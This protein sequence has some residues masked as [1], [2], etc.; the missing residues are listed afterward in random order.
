M[1]EFIVKMTNTSLKCGCDNC[2]LNSEL[3]E[4]ENYLKDNKAPEQ[5]NEFVEKLYGLYIHEQLDHDVLKAIVDNNWSSAEQIMNQSGWVR[6][7]K[8][9]SD[10]YKITITRE[11][12]E[13]DWVFVGKSELY[14]D[15]TDYADDYDT[16]LEL[17]VDSVVTTQKILAKKKEAMKNLKTSFD[18]AY[19]DGSIVL[20][21]ICKYCQG[22]GYVEVDVGQLYECEQC[23]KN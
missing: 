15:L 9:L 23:K 12:L 21:P 11:H 3:K 13:G 4:L 6:K 7:G 16:A 5:F 18:K 17:I 10:K 2:K 8:E 22:M 1:K 14:P 20:K 19:E